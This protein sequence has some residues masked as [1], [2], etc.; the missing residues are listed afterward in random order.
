[1]RMDVLSCWASIASATATIFIAILTFTQSRQNQRQLQEM[2]LNR[3]SVS[4]PNI[5]VEVSDDPGGPSPTRVFGDS[6]FLPEFD[7][8][9]KFDLRKNSSDIRACFAYITFVNAGPGH[10]YQVEVSTNGVFHQVAGGLLAG[11]TLRV[12]MTLCY[13]EKVP[14]AVE[15]TIAYRSLAGERHSSRF[16]LD[17][18]MDPSGVPK[19]MGARCIDLVIEAALSKHTLQ[20]QKRRW[21]GGKR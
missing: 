11:E 2:V 21:F 6:E 7:S 14:P 16:Q 4:S 20:K 8:P 17:L 10:A 18:A 5:T 3:R 1:M 12:P 13:G 19:L 15:L 9:F